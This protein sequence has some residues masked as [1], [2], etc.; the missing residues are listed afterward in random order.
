MDTQL[1]NMTIEEFKEWEIK[2]T[3]KNDVNNY[4]Y[5]TRRINKLKKT[6]REMTDHELNYIRKQYLIYIERN[7]SLP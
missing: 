1:K 6:I 2:K 4:Y 5:C 7:G 3:L